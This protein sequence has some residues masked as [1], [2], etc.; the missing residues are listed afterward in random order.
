MVESLIAQSQDSDIEVTV[1]SGLVIEH[2]RLAV[3]KGR[4]DAEAVTL[5]F[6]GE[7]IDIN[8]KGRLHKWPLGF[9]DEQVRVLRELVR[10]QGDTAD[11]E[12][13]SLSV[14]KFYF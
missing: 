14:Q 8:K 1:G 3:A 5:M 12:S 6:Q 4:I 7:R 11:E 2:L 13:L 10:R 9:C